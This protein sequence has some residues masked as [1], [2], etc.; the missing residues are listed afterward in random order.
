MTKEGGAKM[1][2]KKTFFTIAATM[3][4]ILMFG[5][6]ALAGTWKWGDYGWYYEFDDGSYAT[7]GVYRINGEKYAFD[8]HG[9]MK[10]DT[11]FQGTKGW[12][13]CTSTGALATNQ[14]VGDYYMGDDGI[15]LT[16]TWTPD[17]YYVDSSGKWDRTKTKQG[18]SSGSSS[19]SSSGIPSKYYTIDGYWDNRD[20][21][22]FNSDKRVDMWITVVPGDEYIA[23]ADFGL[24]MS[25]GTPY[26]LYDSNN[27][28]G[29]SLKLGT[30]DGL[31][32]GARSTISDKWYDLEYDGKDTIVLKWRS[33]QWTGG[34]LV[35]KRRSGGSLLKTWSAGGVG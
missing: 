22:G 11:W 16:D 10:S 4:C 6:T 21:T 15:M 17:G 33:T 29:D 12:Y 31:N 24:Y 28:N 2:A 13:Y 32:W 30:V 14:W 9:W 20:Q 34:N 8:K 25:T 18:S 35:F 7:N 23:S 26:S 5:L 3:F 19:S 27:P 1:K